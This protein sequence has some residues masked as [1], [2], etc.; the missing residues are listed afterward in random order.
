MRRYVSNS[1]QLA[2][3]WYGGIGR[4]AV[5]YPTAF[6]VAVALGL[7]SLGLVF[8]ASERFGASATE[9]GWLAG[10]WSLC[11][12]VGCFAIRPRFEHVL[13]RYVILVAMAIMF[14]LALGIRM[15][16][17]LGW[18]FVLYALHGLTVSNFWPPL[19]GWLSTDVEGAVLGRVVS[20]FN[21]SWCL[22]NIVSPYL[23]GWLS[24]RDLR[25][26]LLVGALIFLAAS[27][28]V[29]GATL[30]MGRASAETSSGKPPP[31]NPAAP[32]TDHSTCLRYPSWVGLFPTYFATGV[33]LSI[34]PL[35]GAEQLHLSKPDIGRLLL[36]RGLFNGLA[37]VALGRLAFW[38][39]RRAPMLAG[40]AVVTAAFVGL[41]YAQGNAAISVLLAIVGLGAGISY[42][43]SIFHGVSGS[44]NRAARMAVHEA[45]LSAGLVFGSGTGG[46]IYQSIGAAALYW[47]CAGLLGAGLLVQSVQCAVM[48]D[49]E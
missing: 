43:A 46:M 29:A 7:M 6:L 2:R 27:I 1:L 21:V 26:P 48:C 39:F 41:A 47:T 19:M 14:A 31:E 33:L 37:F 13:P 34:F 35:I 45:V 8:H 4:T 22:G 42:S 30:A 49:G 18:V 11:Y 17:S 23:A 16:P 15:A 32:L 10:A 40:Q 5:I 38:H 28:F 3:A 25:L 24:A 20:R 36:V 44:R 9:V 12:V